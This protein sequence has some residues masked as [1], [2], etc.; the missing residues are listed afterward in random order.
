MLRGHQA[1]ADAEARL[2]G[3]GRRRREVGDTELKP[4]ASEGVRRC[5]VAG[6]REACARSGLVIEWAIM[7]TEGM[8]PPKV[9]AV[10]L[11]AGGSARM[12]KP[13]LLL[14]VGGRPMLRR[15]TET[16]CASGLAQVIVV[17]GA[18]AERVART[19]D[20]FPVEIVVNEGWS[21]GLSTSVR[22]GLGA[23]DPSVQAALMI[24]G[25]QP[26]LTR[27]LIQ[28][29]VDRYEATGALI[30]APY[31]EGK[32]G[33]PVLFDRALFRELL[34]VQGDQGGRSVLD[35]HEQAIAHVDVN[36]AAIC[37][38]VDTPQD[39]HRVSDLQSNDRR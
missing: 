3:P 36:D 28:A 22:A 29:L 21:Q 13:K 17:V 31:Y 7:T 26:M 35:R 10:I 12:G 20:S 8:G 5:S 32:R 1:T 16:V 15:V 39:Y 23:V 6:F 2:K 18:S 9:A 30:V 25:D 33:N 4:P 37:L 11:A 19:L 38:D 27:E 14:P 34:G 24:L